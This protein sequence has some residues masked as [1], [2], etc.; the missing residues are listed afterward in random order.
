MDIQVFS[1]IYDKRK[2]KPYRL[3]KP[4]NDEEVCQD[5]R[6]STGRVSAII[7][8]G[9]AASPNCSQYHFIRS[10]APLVSASG[11][12]RKACSVL[13]YNP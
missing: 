10:I 4:M 3:S 1:S 6:R 5:S 9:N 12:N 8:A 2:T 7:I 13:S 11:V